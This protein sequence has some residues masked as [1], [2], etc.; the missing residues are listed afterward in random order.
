M[1]EIREKNHEVRALQKVQNHDYY[2][3]TRCED[4][5]KSFDACS[6]TPEMGQAQVVETLK[7]HYAEAHP[8]K[9]GAEAQLADLPNME[10]GEAEQRSDGAMYDVALS[11]AGEDRAHAE[12]LADKLRQAGVSV[13]YDRFEQSKLWGRN[14]YDYLSDL[15][16]NRAKFCVMFVSKHYKNKVWTNHERQSAQAKAFESAGE[17]ILPIRLDSTEIPGLHNTVGYLEWPPE[18]AE[19]ACSALMEK[20][21]DAK[22]RR[23][24]RA[25]VRHSVPHEAS[26]VIPTIPVAAPPSLLS[27]LAEAIENGA[28]NLKGLARQYAKHVLGRLDALAIPEPADFQQADDIIEQAVH[29]F[30]LVRNEVCHLAQLGCDFECT[31]LF[32]VFRDMFETCLSYGAAQDR[33]SRWAMNGMYEARGIALQDLFVRVVA[34]LFQAKRFQDL[35]LLLNHEYSMMEF[36]EH[37]AVAYVQFNSYPQQLQ[38]LRNHKRKA[39]GQREW[40]SVHAT[41]LEANDQVPGQPFGLVIQADFLLGLRA[42]FRSLGGFRRWDPMTV[43]YAIK[44]AQCP[45]PAFTMAA[46]PA[47]F[48]ELLQFLGADSKADFLERLKFAHDTYWGTNILHQLD[49]LHRWECFLNL[50]NLP[51]V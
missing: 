16:K 40:L 6:T 51:E 44:H 5:G 37:K 15:Y 39:S 14:L 32:E 29:T 50:Q 8:L 36:G 1:V 30:N 27:R 19:T 45:F 9:N 28:P 21:K 41:V 22:R 25:S 13:F 33:G 49:F 42:A 35:D 34:I 10:N 48:E 2:V 23:A 3:T 43:V 7:K 20:L 47:R 4:C 38:I 31:A 11:F 18:T 12:S 24:S 26:S 17:Y 46:T